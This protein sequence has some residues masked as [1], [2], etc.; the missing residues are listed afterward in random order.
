MDK[1]LICCCISNRTGLTYT[2]SVLVKLVN[3]KQGGALELQLTGRIPNGWS[4]SK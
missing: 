3:R 1:I 2:V 4:K